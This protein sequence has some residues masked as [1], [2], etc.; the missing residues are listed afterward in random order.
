VVKRVV[1]LLLL[2]QDPEVRLQYLKVG[3][4]LAPEAI[5]QRRALFP[6]KT[7]LYHYGKN[8]RAGESGVA[9]SI[10]ALQAC[11]RLTGCP[12]LSAHLNHHTD[13][14]IRALLTRGVRPPPYKAEQALELLCAAVERVQAS[15]PVPLILENVP[16]WP[17][18][19]SDLVVMPEF[20]GRVLEETDCGFLLDTAHARLT[21]ACLAWDVHAYLQA[22]PL[23][24]V[25]EIHA[26][27]PWLEGDRWV[28]SHEPLQ[29]E[30]YA[31]LVWLLQRTSPRVVTL[32][33]WRDPDRAREQLV[34]LNRLLAQARP[35]PGPPGR[36]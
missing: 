7:F 31:L 21:A 35:K 32:E 1:D 8:L 2:L 34:R 5:P 10:A 36:H 14:E 22:L 24:R 19:E 20:I 17:L 12:W 11:Q 6:N 28:D 33:Y 16:A 27:G 3:V 23:E 18:P 15:L 13:D 30:D 25:V 29:E 9:A 26:S 4:W